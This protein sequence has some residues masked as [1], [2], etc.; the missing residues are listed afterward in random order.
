MVNYAVSACGCERWYLFFYGEFGGASKHLVDSHVGWVERFCE[1]Q[2]DHDSEYSDAGVKRLF[3]IPRWVNGKHD[4]K[5][6]D[7]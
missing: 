6:F 4:L 7:D 3:G 2:H 1:T 5:T